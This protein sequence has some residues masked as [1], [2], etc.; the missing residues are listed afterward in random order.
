MHVGM[1]RINFG[2][3]DRARIETLKRYL[4]T[5]DVKKEHIEELAHVYEI[6]DDP[7]FVAYLLAQVDV[8]EQYRSQ[9]TQFL[10]DTCKTFEDMFGLQVVEL[11]D[12]YRA[13]FSPS[14]K[15]LADHIYLTSWSAYAVL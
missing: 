7:T 4:A 6:P 2:W 8:V 5:Y 9:W 10:L 12:A 1:L 14:V 13:T 3:Q 11:L 15:R